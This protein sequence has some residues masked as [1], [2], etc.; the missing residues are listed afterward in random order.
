MEPLFNELPNERVLTQEGTMNA[1]AKVIG[2]FTSI[3]AV[4][5]IVLGVGTASDFS[6][7]WTFPQFVAAQETPPGGP[8]PSGGGQ[9]CLSR[10]T[11]K[12][13][14]YDNPGN[15]DSWWYTICSGCH[16]VQ[17]P[18]PPNTRAAL[19]PDQR[20]FITD[21]R[22]FWNLHEDAKPDPVLRR[23]LPRQTLKPAGSV[24]ADFRG[25]MKQ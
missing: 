9:G 15:L 23:L 20:K 12:G 19:A 18:P 6:N 25:L 21:Y 7:S 4:I 14:L 3:I 17:A 11:C 24:P 22:A 16:T 8:A 5:A 13:T 1:E 10:G 2:R